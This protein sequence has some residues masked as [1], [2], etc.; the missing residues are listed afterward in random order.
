MTSSNSAHNATDHAAESLPSQHN[1]VPYPDTRRIRRAYLL[2][3]FVIAAAALLIYAVLMNAASAQQDTSTAIQMHTQ[4]RG[5]VHR[6]ALIVSLLLT[7][8]NPTT[9]F[10]LQTEGY[11]RLDSLTVTQADI[12][13][14]HALDLLPAE[15]SRIYF[16][17]PSLL[18]AQLGE[19]V[20]LV[21]QVADLP[22]NERTADME[23][24]FDL[25]V[26]IRTSYNEIISQYNTILSSQINASR[27]NARIILG[28]CS[29]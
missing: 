20:A 13:D 23:Q 9:R 26:T 10:E 21:E 22:P 15:V 3:L 28:G 24:I 6:V 17:P 27:M 8:E 1:H 18:D 5:D 14:R 16:A 12:I 11:E 19:Y 29:H 7:E 4:Q 2:S 25:S